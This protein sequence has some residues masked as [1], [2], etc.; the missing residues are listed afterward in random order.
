MT[1]SEAIQILE[2]RLA[3]LDERIREVRRGVDYDKAERAAL[4]KALAKLRE[5]G[6]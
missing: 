4:V 2:R 1:D 6:E 3:H 5:E